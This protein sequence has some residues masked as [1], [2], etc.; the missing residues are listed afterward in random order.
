MTT[1]LMIFVF[2][3]IAVAV[4]AVI[5]LEML[6][7]SDKENEKLQDLLLR[8]QYTIT[9]Y[10][11]LIERMDKELAKKESLISILQTEIEEK[12]NKK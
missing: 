2:L 1:E 9:E 6:C 3:F 4:G 11:C 5:S 8:Q 10:E 7:R 12:E